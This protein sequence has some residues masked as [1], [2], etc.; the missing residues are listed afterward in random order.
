MGHI[1]KGLLI[2]KRLGMQLLPSA[3]CKKLYMNLLVNIDKMIKAALAMCTNAQSSYLHTGSPGTV[4]DYIH[5]IKNGLKILLC[6]IM[7]V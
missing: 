6:T 3:S 4:L 2:T 1:I 7:A 5:V